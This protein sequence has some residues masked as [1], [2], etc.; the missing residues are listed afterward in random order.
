M[1]FLVGLDTSC[2]HEEFYIELQFPT[3]DGPLRVHEPLA[4]SGDIYQAIYPVSGNSLDYL[5]D[6]AKVPAPFAVELRVAG[7][8]GFLLT[9]GPDNPVRERDLLGG[10]YLNS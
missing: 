6:V 10:A 1:Q 3:M 9:P 2:K 8:Q 5:M 4:L 7:S